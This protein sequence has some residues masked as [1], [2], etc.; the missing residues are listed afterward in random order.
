MSNVNSVRLIGNLGV[1]P[2]LRYTKNGTPVAN[3]RMATNEFRNGK[4]YTEW[5]RIVVWGK[6]ATTCAQHLGKGRL[7]QVEGRLQTRGWTD[8]DGQ[9]RYTTEIVGH[10]V[11]FLDRKSSSGQQVQSTEAAEAQAEAPEVGGDLELSAEA[12]KLFSQEG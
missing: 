9:Q 7:I 6:T 3:F 4:K 2:E 10:S 1:D 11:L 12:Q 8:R 5:H